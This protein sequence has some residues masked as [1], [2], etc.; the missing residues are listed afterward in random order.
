ME[1]TI[2]DCPTV[3]N[4]INCGECPH[5][6]KLRMAP[7]LTVHEIML[8][9]LSK[10][11]ETAFH[12]IFPNEKDYENDETFKIIKESFLNWNVQTSSEIP[13]ESLCPL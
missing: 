4:I 8:G 1:T 10:I 2:N 6:C 9:E 12:A 7:K 5:E 13:P 11:S 3:N